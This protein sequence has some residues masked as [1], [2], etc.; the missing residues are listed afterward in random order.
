M[1]NIKCNKC[2]QVSTSEE[3]FNSTADACDSDD[4][5]SIEEAFEDEDNYSFWYCPK[6]NEEVYLDDVE[7]L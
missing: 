5:Y 7:K 1:S 6:C 3:W 2:N 4:I